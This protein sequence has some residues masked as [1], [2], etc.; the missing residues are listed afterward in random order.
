[1]VE[2]IRH[3]L[4]RSNAVGAVRVEDAVAV[5]PPHAHLSLI[6]GL[7]DAGRRRLTVSGRGWEVGAGGGFVIPP[8]TPH[9]WEADEGGAHRVLIL[10][11]AAL[12]FPAWSPCVIRNAE[13]SAAFDA[14]HAIVEAGEGG[15]SQAAERLLGLTDAISPRGGRNLPSPG[16]VKAARREVRARLEE[17][18]DLAELG[19]RVGLSPYHL[20]RLY[21]ATW[22]LTPAEHRLEARLREARRMLLAGL[23][24]A[25][26]AQAN[27]FA[28]QSHLSRAFRRLMGLPPVAWLRQMRKGDTKC[29]GGV[30]ESR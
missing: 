16:P 28:D 9:A 18:L 8:D 7:V 25:E 15:A 21:R 1:M 17:P 24:P 5:V 26:V 2:G 30:S 20:H 6:L 10:D 14:L 12:R 19:R 27:G 11:P 29:R 13:W 4:D 23:P 22:G 3:S